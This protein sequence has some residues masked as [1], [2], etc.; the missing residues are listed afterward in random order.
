MSIIVPLKDQGT[1]EQGTVISLFSL[2][3]IK[4]IPPSIEI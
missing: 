4:L 2:Q 3:T 1:L